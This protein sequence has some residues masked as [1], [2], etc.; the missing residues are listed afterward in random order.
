MEE[1]KE[2][3]NRKELNQSA[4]ELSIDDFKK[5]YGENFSSAVNID[6]WRIGENLA[7]L[8]PIIEKELISAKQDEAKTHQAFREKI[9]PRIK[10]KALVPHAGLNND[11]YQDNSLIKKVH[12]G[13]LFNGSV[14]AC[15]STSAIYDTVPISI[16][17][18]GICLVNYQG[19]HG[20]YSHRLFRRDLRFKSEDPI[21]EAINLI[22]RRK[23]DEVAGDKRGKLSTLAIRGIKTYAERAILLE[24]KGDANWLLG[25]GSPAPYELMTGFWASRKE[26]K[27][28]SIGLMQ[29]MVLDHQKF[30]YIQNSIRNPQ[31]WTFGNAL[32]PYEY[33][34]ID[35]I[36]DDLIRMVDQGGTRGEFRK[37]YEQFAKQV[38]SKIVRGVYKVS[39]LSSPQIFYCHIDHIKVAALI[40][41]AD[42]VLQLH[43]G[44]PMLLDLADNL[45]QTAFGKSDFVASIEQA[46]AKA[47][48]L[49]RITP[50]S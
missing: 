33:L 23:G 27:D 12:H 35:T 4:E 34:V 30:V 25:A 5:A 19:Q 22:E 32:R 36:E 2:A 3:Q 49:A 20:S 47:E 38:G 45:C 41:M 10:E 29:K 43:K 37:S 40:A 39:N 6:T 11:L 46:Y 44:S 8:Y 16:T 15:G 7:E 18:I 17:Q 1:D 24:K 9:F 13:F 31:L 26:M 42:S 28:K 21:K 48:T 50:K 14:L